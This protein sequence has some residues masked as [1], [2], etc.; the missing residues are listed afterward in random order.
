[1][2]D[3]DAKLSPETIAAYLRSHPDFFVDNEELLAELKIPHRSGPA[4]SLVEKQQSVLRERNTELRHRLTGLV[5]NARSNDRLFGLTRRVVLALL[6]SKDLAQAVDI[7]YNSFGDEFGVEFTQIILFDE[8]PLCRARI[9]PLSHAQ[10]VIGKYLK[11]RQTIGGGLGREERDFLFGE[12]SPKVGS[13]AMAVLAYGDVYGVLAIGNSDPDYY[14]SSMGTLF[15]GYI[16]EVFSRV[17]RD[18]S[19]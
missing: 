4:V 2:T 9:E 10:R 8:S 17:I 13:A 18:H 11:A 5:D 16:A 6:D 19:F 3:T 1:M 7:I 14:Q 15:L 12:Q